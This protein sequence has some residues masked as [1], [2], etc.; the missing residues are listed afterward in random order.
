[1]AIK[2]TA[3]NIHQI[4]ITLR[5]VRPP[6]TRRIQVKADTKLGKLHHILQIV[7]GWTNSHLH[8][9]RKGQIQY[10]PPSRDFFNDMDDERKVRLDSLVNEGGTLMYEYDFGDGWEHDLKIEKVIP[11]EAGVHYPRCLTGK[12]NCPPEDCGG[13]WGYQNLLETLADPKHEDHESMR[14]W[15]GRDFDP[16]EFDLDEVNA[17]LRHVK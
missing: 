6:V 16:E 13:P 11:A 2:K 10:G 1:M 17:G 9:F 12:R 7:L 14:E 4:K 8:A 15:L 5:H 3:T